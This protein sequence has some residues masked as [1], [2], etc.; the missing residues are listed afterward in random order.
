MLKKS[1]DAAR[2]ILGGDWQMPTK[3]IWE[4]LKGSN[5]SWTWTTQGEH[6]GYSI[7]NNTSTNQSIFLPAAGYYENE[8]IVYSNQI[9]YYWS[10]TSNYYENAFNLKLDNSTHAFTTEWRYFGHSIRP[11]RLIKIE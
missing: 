9:G 2:I 11:V 5:Y 10:S 7:N 3:E 1:N 4:A 6:D 8:T